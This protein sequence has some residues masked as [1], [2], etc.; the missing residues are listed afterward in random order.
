MLVR[1]IQGVSRTR[2]ITSYNAYYGFLKGRSDCEEFYHFTE[3]LN[4]YGWAEYYNWDNR[5]VRVEVVEE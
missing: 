4:R 5:V 3:R 2:L 1:V